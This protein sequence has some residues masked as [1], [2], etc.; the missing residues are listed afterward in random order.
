MELDPKKSK[1]LKISLVIL[2]AIILLAIG[3]TLG[4]HFSHH[5]NYGN[6]NCANFSK[7]ER[8]GR[9]NMIQGGRRGQ[10]QGGFR[11]MA[12]QNNAVNYNN[13]YQ[14]QETN[15]IPQTNQIPFQKSPMRPVVTTSTSNITP[16]NK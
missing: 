5:R 8:N 7:F 12:P 14:N 6:N 11:M 2:A 15:Q 4:S 13:Q 10:A 3:G 16:V 9:Q 1:A